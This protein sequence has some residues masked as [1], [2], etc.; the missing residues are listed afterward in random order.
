[1]SAERR[2]DIGSKV[3][4]A[5]VIILTATIMGFSI[6]VASNAMAKAQGNE[7]AIGK[8][9]TFQEI[10][11]EDVKEIRKDVKTILNKL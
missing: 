9:E 4:T 5:V 3:L 10:M 1:M 8:V 11:K 6:N 2:N 7:V